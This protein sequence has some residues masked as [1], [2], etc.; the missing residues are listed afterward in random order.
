M[1]I[2]LEQVDVPIDREVKRVGGFLVAGILDPGVGEFAIAATVIFLHLV[3]QP[4]R[5]TS[6]PDIQIAAVVYG[7]KVRPGALPC[8]T[9]GQQIV[10]PIGTI[11][12]VERKRA[13]FA[14]L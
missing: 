14:G 1:A 4:R 5:G 12:K 13:G 7:S 11:A 2:G 3:G 8:L 10:A 9:A 6:I